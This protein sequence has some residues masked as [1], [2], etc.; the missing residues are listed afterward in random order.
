MALDSLVATGSLK[1]D[2]DCLEL[3]TKDP[4]SSSELHELKALLDDFSLKM[5]GGS[6]TEE[7]KTSA[8]ALGRTLKSCLKVRSVAEKAATNGFDTSQFEKD[9]KELSA[10]MAEVKAG[11]ITSER[12][13]RASCL[14]DKVR[15]SLEIVE[16]RNTLAKRTGAKKRV[17]LVLENNLEE[18]RRGRNIAVCFMVD[19]TYSMQSYIDG[20][21]TQIGRVV[22]RYHKLHPDSSLY[23][24]F[25][26]YR[27]FDQPVFSV[28]PFTSSL[29]EFISFVGTVSADGGG[30]QCEDVVG[31][32]N[33]ATN[34]DW[35]CAG[36]GSSRILVHIAD[37]PA[38][39]SEYNGGCGDN[40]ADTPTPNAKS[41][42]A[43]PFLKALRAANVHYFFFRVNS[44]CDAM[45]EKF[46]EH[47]RKVGS[48]SAEYVT[49]QE[50]SAVEDLADTV[51]KT[52]SSSVMRTHAVARTVAYSKLSSQMSSIAEG[53]EESVSGETTISEPDDVEET[54]ASSI[55]W[56]SIPVREIKIMICRS[57][58]GIT[59]LQHKTQ[60]INCQAMCGGRD[61]GTVMKWYDRAPFAKGACRW[62]YWGKVQPQY[63]GAWQDFVLKRFIGATSQHSKFRYMKTMEES[64]TA[65]FLAQNYNARR[66]AGCKPIR[67]LIAT[68]VEM[69]LGEV[70]EYFSAEEALP[71]GP[72][73]KFCNNAGDWDET[74]ID[75]SLLEFAKYT[76]DATGGYMMV[77]DL[78]GVD[79]GSEF[80]LTDPAV[81]CQDVDRFMDTNF[82]D[83]GLKVNYERVKKYLQGC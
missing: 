73:L 71:P 27:D 83:K 62:A 25:V 81:V 55:P 1:I 12:H 35:E 67:F 79:A 15:D 47:M 31:G 77:T 61:G 58:T 56:S 43:S 63:G 6:A 30:D 69:K 82:G 32:L 52:F 37:A 74:H 44:C 2:T 65:F 80:V 70:V 11:T 78:Q 19:C 53:D 7:D 21:K 76:Y 22:Q 36:K 16:M 41:K 34:L 46:N 57:P 29:P 38:H 3:M 48:K 23:F 64:T 5:K 14:K 49:M 20:V 54:K 42:D 59:S 8:Q 4:R 66:R 17:S 50:L 60:A 40:W 51:L 68:V 75:R 13:A 72:F 28:K 33:E 45:V 39:G 24:A 10:L 26:G 18:A 9:R